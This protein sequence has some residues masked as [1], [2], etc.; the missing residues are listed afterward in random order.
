MAVALHR[1]FGKV[2]VVTPRG[3]TLFDSRK[4]HHM[5]FFAMLEP[6]LD[7]SRWVADCMARPHLKVGAFGLS[8]LVSKSVNTAFRVECQ[9][10]SSHRRLKT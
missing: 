6:P 2:T 7:S 4:P 9:R 8:S 1:V 5:Y 3:Q 10:C